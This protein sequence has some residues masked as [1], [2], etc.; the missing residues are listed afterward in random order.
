MSLTLKSEAWE[1]EVCPDI[2]GALAALRMGGLDVLRPFG[3]DGSD[4]LDTSCFPL[5]PYCNRIREGRFEWNG[6]AVRMPH[7]FAPETSSI[8]GL[9]WQSE[10]QVISDGGFKCALEHGH[11]ASVW[12]WAY[13]AQQRI[14]LGPRGL[15]VSLDVTNR[16]DTAMPCGIGLHP[17]FRRRPETK[18]RF[19]TTGMLAVD[20]ALIPTG[21]ILSPDYFADW[22]AGAGLPDVLVDHSFTGWDGQVT[23][24]DELGTITMTARGAPALHVYAPPDGSA[25]CFEPVSHLP[26]ALN[27]APRQMTALPPGCSATLSM[28]V[29]AQA[30]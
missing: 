29:S 24:E 7:N 15:A 18:V 25:L 11:D 13:H 12:P 23:I 4:P 5:I 22:Q 6:R 26:D 27:Q 20:E 16:G 3:G 1:A 19:V 17:Y 28:W 2:G 14:R 8:H 21:E 10:W 30:R 9:A